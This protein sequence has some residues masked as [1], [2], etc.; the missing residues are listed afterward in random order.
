MTD[1]QIIIDGKKE[2]CKILFD[3][4]HIDDSE[5]YRMLREG[6][7]ITPENAPFDDFELRLVANEDSPYGFTSICKRN[8][9]SEE[10]EYSGFGHSGAASIV[11]ALLKALSRKEQECERLQKTIDEA[12]NS[13]LDLKSFLVGEAMQNEYEQQ[14]DQLKTELNSAKEL[15]EYTYNCCKQAGEELAKNSFEWDGK[16]KN[17]VVQAMELNERYDQLKAELEA[18][19]MEAEEGKEINAELKAENDTY[20]KMLEDEDVQ[21][22]LTEIR[23][24]ERHIWYNKAEK[25]SKTLAEIKEV[26]KEQLP[27]VNYNFAK[28]MHPEMFNCYEQ[29]LQ[30]ISECEEEDGN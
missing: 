18:Y 7:K 12:K 21:L 15:R 22:A 9:N 14:I 8:K 20:K 6:V 17:L 3:C 25:L 23:S 2:D 10:W 19:K 30:K 5:A 1:K 4:Y 28:S 11:T 29:I 16:E 24:G 27:T 13:K 26:V